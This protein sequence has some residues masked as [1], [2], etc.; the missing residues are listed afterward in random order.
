MTTLFRVCLLLTPLCFS[1]CTIH[2]VGKHKA[3]TLD[4]GNDVVDAA[5]YVV[6]GA[7]LQKKIHAEK[8]RNGELNNPND[9]VVK[10]MNQA[11]EKAKDRKH[12]LAPVEQDSA[13]TSLVIKKTSQS[14]GGYS[15]QRRFDY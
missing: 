4:T 6:A 1:A 15:Q 8:L 7:K 11:I 9:P 12:G 5:S 3:I 14:G 13:D 2:S 10:Q